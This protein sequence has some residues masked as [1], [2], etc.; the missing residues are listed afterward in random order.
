MS[1]PDDAAVAEGVGHLGGRRRGDLDLL[2]VDLKLFGNH[3]GHLGK[4]PL[5]HFSAAMVQMNAAIL[6]DMDQ[7]ARL[8]EV[9]GGEGNAEL[10]RSECNAL[11]EIR[12]VGIELPD[13]LTA[14]RIVGRHF[15]LFNELAN[16][17]VLDLHV[18][19]RQITALA[20][21]EVELANLQRVLAEMIGD[22]VDHPF[23]GDHALGTAKTAECRVGDRMG[24]AAVR[25]DRGVAQEIAVVRMEH[26]PVADRRRQVRRHAAARRVDVLDA[27][28]AAVIVEADIVVDAEV[29]ALAGH[30]HVVVAVEP[31]LGGPAGVMHDKRG[32]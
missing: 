29:V 25:G 18:I 5:P 32:D 14:G 11:L 12:A 19:G 15:K 6:V 10:D 1:L 4:E 20:A 27:F 2:D 17:I 13:L 8:I 30:D 9:A 31:D 24:L 22:R 3:L 7:G 28:D 26:G 16:D 23:H 21:I